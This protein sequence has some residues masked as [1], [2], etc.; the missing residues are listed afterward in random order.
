VLLK[1]NSTNKVQA[2]VKAMA[3]GLLNSDW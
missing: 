3:M 2:V 1:L